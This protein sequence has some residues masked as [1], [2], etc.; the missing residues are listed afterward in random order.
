MDRSPVAAGLPPGWA[1]AIVGEVA[2]LNPRDLTFPPDDNDLVSFIPM[3]SVEPGSGRIGRSEARRWK[4]VR[5]GYTR[6]QDGDLVFA[7]ITPC[8]ENGKFALA[9][10][11][12][13]GRGA[14]STEFHVL[15][16]SA[17]VEPRFLLYYLLQESVR[18][19]ARLHMRGAAGQ[20]RVPAEFLESLEIPLPPRSEQRRIVA[21]IEAQFSRL[22][23][24]VTVLKRAQAN[25]KR[26]RAAVLASACEGRLVP[27][28]EELARREGRD[29]E[30]AAEMLKS[31]LAAR[32]RRWEETQRE[33]RDAVRTARYPEPSPPAPT[34]LP[35][36]PAGWTWATWDQL[37][38]RVTVGHVGPMKD[39]YVN[40]GVPFLRSQNVR[41][42]RF[43]PAGL[44]FIPPEF[45]DELAKSKLRPGD[46]AVVRSGSVGVTCVIP[47]HI[48][49]ANCADL[50]II[51]EPMGVEP[52]Y[53]AYYMNSLAKRDIRRQTVGVAL[54]HF[55][56]K[57]VA[58][59]SVAVP[60]LAEQRRI[61]AEV[62]R[63]LTLIDEAAHETQRSLRRAE[64]LR[65]SILKRAFEGKLVPQDP[66]DEPA[67][68]LL[69]RIRA[70]RVGQTQPR[71]KRRPAASAD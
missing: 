41:E 67:S 33:R 1:H 39:R 3:A 27:T 37:A 45:H 46:L 43:D 47:D 69:E 53:G 22:D 11:L 55:N 40:S 28:E 64:R 49:D 52:Q 34:S 48:Q 15:R 44:L 50:V 56:T 17:V 35:P 31:V 63:R 23:A 4:D 51:Q 32:H 12:L 58:A 38:R 26:Y 68:V 14:G 71:R 57:S 7:K 20:L 8:M 16:A 59:L 62:E 66:S 65:Q 6:F 18:R 54:S 61:V 60:P 25:L 36:L 9:D 19:R 24:A 42:N 5:K 21:E 2:E 13:Q 70:E 10:G 29:Y 30:T